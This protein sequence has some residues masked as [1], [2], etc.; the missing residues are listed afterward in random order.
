MAMEDANSV[1]Y[2]TKSLYPDIAKKYKTT[3]GSVERAIRHAVDIV[4]I[5]GNKQLLGEIF[6]TFVIEQQERPTNSEFIAAVADWMRLEY[7]I[8]VS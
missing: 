8:R 7:Q 3:I 2:I 1:N 4:W 5:R 6:G